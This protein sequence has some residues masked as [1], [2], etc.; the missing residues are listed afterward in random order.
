M[1]VQ[2]NVN[3]NTEAAAVCGG[4]AAA[5]VE[6]DDVSIGA[7]KRHDGVIL[8]VRWQVRSEAGRPHAG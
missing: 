6:D 7:N 3:C 8:P 2:K 5:A 4:A 1:D